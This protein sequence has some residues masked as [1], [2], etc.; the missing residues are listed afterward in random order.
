M[1][2][3]SHVYIFAFLPAT[4]AIYF[5]LGR[6]SPR[7]G[8]LALAAAS[9]FFYGWW[10]PAYVGLLLAST[11]FNYVAG[12]AIV[13]APARLRRPALVAGIAGDLL[14][15]AYYKYWAF[16]LNS[17]ALLLGGDWRVEAMVLP[18]GIS[19]FTF[20]QIAFLVDA[21]RGEAREPSPV[22]YALFVSFFPHLLAGPLLHHK[23]MMPQF[24]DPAR[25]RARAENFSVGLTI[26]IIGLFK[27]TV[28]ADGVA[29]FA[30]PVFAE[31]A[32]GGA[33]GLLEAW[34]GALAY[35]FQLYFDFSGYSDM[36]IGAARMFGIVMPINFFSPYKATSITEFWRRWH[37]TLSRFLRDYLYIPLGGSRRGP[38][39]RYVNLMVTM[40][41]GG[42][43]HGAAW[44]FVA[45]G[46]LHGVYLVVHH[47]WRHAVAAAG[48]AGKGGAP[49]RWAGRLLTFVAVVFGWVLFRAESFDGATRIIAGMV[50]ANGWGEVGSLLGPWSGGLYAGRGETLWLAGLALVVFALPNTQEFMARFRPALAPAGFERPAWLAWGAQPAWSIAMVVALLVALSRLSGLSEFLYY[51]F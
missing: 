32:Q 3:N 44:T 28:L 24:A 16:A 49:G 34:G 23:E 15:L 5:A 47:A 40:V 10:N 51:Q 19:F 2:F 41:L 48:L 9:F 25:Y 42:L 17:A 12:L 39:R 37:M 50:G 11:V 22:H 21:W 33:P 27:K 29:D 18:I 14:V 8:A 13:H 31:A 6:T 35:T 20:T 26:F 4:L 43:W 38:A 46:A 45:W 30:A 7:G 36:A 1:L